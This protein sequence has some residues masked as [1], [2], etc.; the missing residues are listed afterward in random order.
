VGL[1]GKG[2]RTEMKTFHSQQARPTKAV[3][4]KAKRAKGDKVSSDLQ[5]GGGKYTHRRYVLTT[6]NENEKNG[7]EGG[8]EGLRGTIPMSQ[9]EKKLG[10]DNASR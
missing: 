4:I 6:R 2:K 9:K 5:E 3:T 7:E 1:E 8:K 10:L